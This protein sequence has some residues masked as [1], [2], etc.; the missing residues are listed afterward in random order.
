MSPGAESAGLSRIALL[1]LTEEWASCGKKRV[2]QP[3]LG[4]HYS[5]T[6]W[7][8]Q[9]KI[10]F[11]VSGQTVLQFQRAAPKEGTRESMGSLQI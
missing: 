9:R 4:L 11:I 10:C 7:Q 2:P 8:G 6:L 5:E 3:Q 1:D